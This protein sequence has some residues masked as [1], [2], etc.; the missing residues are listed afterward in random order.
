[1]T[2]EADE[3]SAASRGSVAWSFQFR[4]VFWSRKMNRSGK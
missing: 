2:D 3:V 4:A 1:M